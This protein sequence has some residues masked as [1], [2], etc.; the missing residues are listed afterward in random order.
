MLISGTCISEQSL[1]SGKVVASSV[2]SSWT[3]SRYRSIN[4]LFFFAHLFDT[5]PIQ[6][7][8]PF[9]FVRHLIDQDAY[10]RNP[11]LASL[12]VDPAFAAELNERQAAWRR[13]I[14]VFISRAFHSLL[15]ATRFFH[16][17]E[18]RMNF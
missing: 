15:C 17:C 1:A 7:N 3:A 11:Q 16:K 8:H 5:I 12:L 2:L 10:E 9:L 18:K 14:Q 6:G 4:L 13:I